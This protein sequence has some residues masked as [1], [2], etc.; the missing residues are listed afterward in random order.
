MAAFVRVESMELRQEIKDSNQKHTQ[1]SKDWILTLTGV[2]GNA[3]NSIGC[4][5]NFICFPSCVL[6]LQY[7][8]FCL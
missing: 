3:P 8:N 6:H 1:R 4:K 5:L 2:D 7:K